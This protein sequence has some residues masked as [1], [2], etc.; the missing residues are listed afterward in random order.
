MSWCDTENN[1]DDLI[2]LII[3]TSG[4]LE[5]K[6]NYEGLSLNLSILCFFYLLKKCVIVLV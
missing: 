1:S 3:S 2:I 6:A 5:N 4:V